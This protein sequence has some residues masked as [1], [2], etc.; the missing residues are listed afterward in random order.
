MLY[1]TLTALLRALLSGNL[2][3]W[4][5]L[6]ANFKKCDKLV[7]LEFVVIVFDPEDCIWLHLRKE[8]FLEQRRSKLMECED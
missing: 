6:L 4:E 3:I 2:K 7:L 1:R 8:M 5:K